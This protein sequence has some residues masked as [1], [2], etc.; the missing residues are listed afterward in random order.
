MTRQTLIKQTVQTLSRLPHEKVQEVADFAEF[1]FKKHDEEILQK[2]IEK[3]VSDSRAFEYL[4]E[5]ED[6]YTVSDLKEK[7]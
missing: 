7:Y 2:G 4:H 5:E 1:L 6:L 3:L